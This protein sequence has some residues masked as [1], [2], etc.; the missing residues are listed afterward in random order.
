MPD[1]SEIIG[2]KDDSGVEWLL[3]EG[4]P[5]WC[6]PAKIGEERWDVP[7][8]D[9]YYQIRSY[10]ISN[11]KFKILKKNFKNKKFMG[12]WM[13]QLKSRYEIFSREYYWS[14]AFKFFKKPYYGGSDWQ[15]IEEDLPQ[16]GKST[17]KVGATTEYFNWEEQYDCS[18][19]AT[20]SFFKPSETIFYGM[21]MR[22]SNCE[23]EFI[24]QD[25]ELVCFD[26]SVNNKSLSCL[27]VRK[28]DFVEFL[29]KNNLEIFWTVLG[30]KRIIGGFHAHSD[31]FRPIETSGLYY[32][33]DNNVVGKINTF[34]YR[35]YKR[36]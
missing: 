34:K 16:T 2:I 9:L 29:T 8:K 33:K 17:G 35:E 30:E 19:E 13:P 28:K 18:K 32:I 12:D 3:L 24:N 10:L 14:P 6:E 15:D 4:H 26:P 36:K 5:R 25:N 31:K 23:G 21:Q 20:L 11:G 22:F 1:P 27:L 7:H